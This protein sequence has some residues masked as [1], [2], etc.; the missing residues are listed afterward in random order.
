MLKGHPPHSSRVDNPVAQ[1]AESAP[2]TLGF[3]TF[4]NGPASPYEAACLNSFVNFGYE[5]TVFSYGSVPGLPKGVRL[6][7]ASSLLGEDLRDKFMYKGKPDIRHFSDYFRF[8]LSRETDLVWID[9]DIILVRELDTNLASTILTKEW[10]DSLCNSVVRI[11]REDPRLQQMIERCE[12]M[13][14]KSLVWG[15]T[16]PRLLTELFA[17]EL[18]AG[19][20]L[21]PERFYP[22]DFDDFWK[23][24]LP[25]YFDECEK[26]TTSAYGVHLW[27]NLVESL[28]LWKR[29]APPVGS[30][31][32]R[33]IELGSA[34]TFFDGT[35]DL[36]PMQQLVNNWRLRK[37]GGDLG[38]KQLARQLIPSVART[39]R[40]YY[41][42]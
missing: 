33:Q 25:E 23:V 9:A 6:Q 13:I 8:I 18:K 31:L 21:G 28:G 19:T 41:G 24:L 39:F 20:C 16:G 5:V 11:D 4:W 15:Q 29:F 30:Y 7:Q 40:H 36:S 1:P 42:H 26:R 14:G 22:I 35:Y 12:A 38:V 3:A 37:S 32:Y 27:N 10:G 34:V 17:Q 2:N